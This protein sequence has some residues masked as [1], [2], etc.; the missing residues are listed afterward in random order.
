MAKIEGRVK[1]KIS[2]G[3]AAVNGLFNGI[4][5]GLAMA[6][7]IVI[8]SL[9]AGKG[10]GYLAYFSTGTPVLPLLGL[11]MHLGVSSIY[12][13]LYGLGR[14]WA[15]LDRL[16]RLPAWLAGLVYAM[17]LWVFAVTLLLPATKALILTLP[18]VVFFTGHIAYGLVLGYRQKP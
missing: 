10:L 1:E 5:G 13:M 17:G 6:A 16:T 4:L 12:G 15:R 14:Q 7:V 18:W 3:D 11:V 2:T 9:L 8:F